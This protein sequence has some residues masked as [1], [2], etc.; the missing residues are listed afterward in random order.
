MRE[1]TTT[2]VIA[3]GTASGIDGTTM[4]S[5]HADAKTPGAC[6]RRAVARPATRPLTP[7]PAAHGPMQPRGMRGARRPAGAR[8]P[9]P[10]TSAEPVPGL[11]GAR[12][13]GPTP[14]PGAPARLFLLPAFALLLGTLSLLAP[15]AVPRPRPRTAQTPT[16][17]FELDTVLVAE[18]RHDARHRQG[19]AERG[20]D[21]ADHGAD[22]RALE[23]HHGAGGG[24]HP[25]RDDAHLR[26]RATRRSPSRS[27][28]PRT[29]CSRA[30]RQITL[31][32]VAPAG[33]PYTLG[34][35]NHIE[36]VI[37]DDS[38]EPGQPGKTTL[39]P[40]ESGTNAP[41]ATT[42]S[43]TIACA[44]AASG[45]PITDFEVRAEA[46]SGAP[47]E[48]TYFF[49]DKKCGSNGPVTL[50]GLPLRATATTW[51]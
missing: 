7:L 16:M 45:W 43:F 44:K 29:R 38:T 33:A 11:R 26:R 49:P 36:I 24:L 32:L 23:R 15:A 30:A 40:V 22:P 51:R 12:A 48:R 31:E 50:T 41:T 8:K 20:P 27:L 6:E 18:D 1:T 10:P 34:S 19:A 46:R 35:T 14:A 2:A 3:G 5:S 47:L 13:A 39:T 21:A 25:V 37:I 9:A 17:E 28:R 4:G 42:L